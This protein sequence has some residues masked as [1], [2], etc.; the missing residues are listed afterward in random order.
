MKRL[1]LAS[2][3][4]LV[5]SSA[6]ASENTFYVRAD[7]GV[8]FM[9]KAT[10]EGFKGKRTNHLVADLGVGTYLMDNVRVELDLAN[11]FNAKQKFSLNG[12]SDTV[13]VN[14]ISL[15]LK[16]LVDIFDYG[17]GKVFAGA[18]TGMTQLSGKTTLLGKAKKKNN[19]NFLGTAGTSFDV[20]EGVMLDVAYSY[21]DHGKTKAFKGSPVKFH[22]KTH[23]ITAGVRVEL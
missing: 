13:K 17:Y 19:V 2:A 18:G 8:A 12:V 14:A 16:A 22:Y 6:I 21:A 5:A 11:A 3:V 4:A 20:S 15:H 23:N 10:V 9:P 1:L 7:A